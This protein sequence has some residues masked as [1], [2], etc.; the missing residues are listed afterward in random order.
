VHLFLAVLLV[1][2]QLTLLLSL[3]NKLQQIPV[4]KKYYNALLAFLFILLLQSILGTTVRMY[5]DDVSKLV[6]Y[7]QRQTWLAAQPIAFML[8][9]SF[10]WA[11]LAGA[12]FLVWQNRKSLILASRFLYLL[13]IVILNMVVGIVLFYADMPAIAQ[14]I[15]LF[16]A[17]AALTYAIYI[18]AQMKK[19]K[20]SL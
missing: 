15:H 19:L 9:R 1:Q 2:I 8:H 11:V 17:S 7:E 12:I 10:S 4:D 16:L 14:P 20:R 18:L 13:V 6:H 3:K 5:V